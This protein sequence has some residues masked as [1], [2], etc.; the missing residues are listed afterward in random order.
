MSV[1][2]LKMRRIA[3]RPVTDL[4]RRMSSSGV[5]LSCSS[6]GRV[7]SSS[8]SLAVMPMPSVWISTM[9]GA[10][11]GKT[12][13]GMERRRS[14]PKYIIAAAAAI[15]RNLNFR[16]DPTIQRII[17]VDLPGPS[18]PSV[19]GA[20]QFSR[21][22]GHHRGAGGRTV[23][24]HRPVAVDVVDADGVSD[25][26]QRLRVG[27][28]PRLALRVVEHRGG[29]NDFPRTGHRHDPF[30]GAS[31]GGGRQLRCARGR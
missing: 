12:S 7:I 2:S 20:K 25:E 18:F 6:I 22:D 16:L 3:D 14:T 30:F 23:Q 1:P 27:V 28:D 26:D 4:E 11:S 15:T 19:L 8:T 21:A 13:T 17:A 29:G 10:N 9:G 31:A 24:E 5:P